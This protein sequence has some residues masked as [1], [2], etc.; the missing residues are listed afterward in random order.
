MNLASGDTD[1]NTNLTEV[2]TLP[3]SQIHGQNIFLSFWIKQGRVKP[4]PFTFCCLCPILEFPFT[5]SPKN[6]TGRERKS[7]QSV[8]DIPSALQLSLEDEP[9]PLLITTVKVWI[10]TARTTI[11]WQELSFFS[12]VSSKKA[13]AVHMLYCQL[14]HYQHGRYGRRAM[15]PDG[16]VGGSLPMTRIWFW[17]G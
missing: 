16:G 8:E 14:A 13:L 4:Y 1:H 3:D 6:T 15:K 9:P 10:S 11:T 2:L 5:S 7:P 12:M 17:K